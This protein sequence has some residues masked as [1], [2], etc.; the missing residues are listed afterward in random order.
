MNEEYLG[1]EFYEMEL[2]QKITYLKE[3]P[4]LKI[5][6]DE[7][8]NDYF[9][10]LYFLLCENGEAELALKV[11]EL[12]YNATLEAQN[13]AYHRIHP[14]FEMLYAYGMHLLG[15]KITPFEEMD[16]EIKKLFISFCLLNGPIF[17]EYVDDYLE[18]YPE[19]EEFFKVLDEI[20]YADSDAIYPR[21]LCNI[22]LAYKNGTERLPKDPEKALAFFEKG[23]ELD[24][25][26]R[27]VS[28]PFQRVADCALEAAICYMKGIGTDKNLDAA[29]EYFTFGAQEYGVDSIPAMAE[30]YLDPDFDWENYFDSDEELYVAAFDAYKEEEFEGYLDDYDEDKK[31]RTIAALED[32]YKRGSLPAAKRLA[33]AYEN[34]ILVE[35]NEEKAVAYHKASMGSGNDGASAL[36]LFEHGTPEERES[37]QLPEALEVGDRFEF[38]SMLK[39]PLVWQVFEKNED[40]LS[41]ITRD[42]VACLPF[43]DGF[44]DYEH[45]TVREWLNKVFYNKVFTEEEKSVINSNK[46]KVASFWGISDT[47]WVDDHVLLIAPKEVEDFFGEENPW[48]VSHTELAILTGGST[49]CWTRWV[50]NRDIPKHINKNGES[51]S[52]FRYRC[53]VSLGIRPVITVKTK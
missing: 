1:A 15:N 5:D 20:A 33:E 34:G 19:L 24:Y 47:T 16:L 45:S 46:F 4:D 11:L 53:G 27:Q 17:T 25:S 18:N 9:E 10:R 22:G 32:L 44:A 3:N 8:E 29:L 28:F 41:L 42:I 51:E 14:S 2:S 23:A 21:I 37:Y 7:V 43:D 26:G 38:G 52:R 40:S 36:Y 6:P 12:Y 50:H 39:K 30:I 31:I 48:E 13:E 35:E 49:D